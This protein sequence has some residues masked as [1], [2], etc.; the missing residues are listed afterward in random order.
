[1]INTLIDLPKLYGKKLHFLRTKKMRLVIRKKIYD[2]LIQLNK[3][4]SQI[5]ADINFKIFKV[6]YLFRLHNC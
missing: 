5:K 2:F 3:L 6:F 4:I 1:M